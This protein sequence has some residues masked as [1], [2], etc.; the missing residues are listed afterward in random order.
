MSKVMCDMTIS[1]DGY[2]AGPNQS[3]ERP[4]GDEPASELHRWMFEEAE[5]NAAEIEA[6]TA[7]GSAGSSPTGSTASGVASHA[8]RD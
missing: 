2:A 7:A 4:F 5:A 1:V 6:I 8:A 3:R